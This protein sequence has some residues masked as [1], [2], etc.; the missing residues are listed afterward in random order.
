MSNIN[1]LTDRFITSLK[2]LDKLES[3]TF[4][5]GEL[6][7][8]TKW[9]EWS[10][11]KGV[12]YFQDDETV[13]YVGCALKSL[14]SRLWVQ[15]KSFGDPDWDKVIKNND[16]IICV[17]CFNDDVWYLSSALEIFLIDICKPKFN[18]RVQ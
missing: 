17:I 7:K 16:V 5:I 11:R 9:G 13:V 15:I 3:F 1:I 12:Y 2:S 14:G 4:T 18:K 6:R 10:K 8:D